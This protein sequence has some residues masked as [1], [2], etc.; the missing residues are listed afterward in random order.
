MDIGRR[1]QL[2]DHAAF[3]VWLGLEA[4]PAVSSLCERPARI[5]PDA[6]ALPIDF[7]V[8]RVDYDSGGWFE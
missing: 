5:G 7:W 3:A 8:R 2:F 6:N 1:V 4:E